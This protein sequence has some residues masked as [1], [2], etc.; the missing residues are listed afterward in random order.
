VHRP[1]FSD[2]WAQKKKVPAGTGAQFIVRIYREFNNNNTCTSVIENEKENIH[3]GQY[4]SPAPLTKKPK[5][6]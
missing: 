5:Q 2:F 6:T 3:F 4:L 1:I